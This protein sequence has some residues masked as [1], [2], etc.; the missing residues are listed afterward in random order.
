[1]AH[2]A[3]AHDVMAAILVYPNN[4]I[5]AM[6]VNQ[7]NPVG[8]QL[9]SYVNTFFA[10]LVYQINPVGVQLFPYENTFSVNLRVCLTRERIRAIGKAWFSYAAELP[11]TWP[12]AR[13]G[14]MLR[15]V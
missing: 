13:P 2:G 15:Y 3:Y 10:M 1:M 14:T 6:L 11:G 7:T 4:K 12:P 9:F 5:L 8:V